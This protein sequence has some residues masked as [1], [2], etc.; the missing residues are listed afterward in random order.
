MQNGKASQGT[1]CIM[2]VTCPACG[3]QTGVDQRTPKTPWS[4][5][6]RSLATRMCGAGLARKTVARVFGLVELPVWRRSFNETDRAWLLSLR[7][8]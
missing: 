8:R 3:N 2:K 5:Q 6:Q 4:D 7:K 1:R